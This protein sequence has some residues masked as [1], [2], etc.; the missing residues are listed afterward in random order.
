MR[1]PFLI[2][3]IALLLTACTQ[4]PTKPAAKDGS[5]I[6]NQ[7]E[8]IER[9]LSEAQNS[10]SPEREQ[11][12]LQ[13]AELLLKANQ[14]DLLE[15]VIGGIEPDQLPL[16]QH[17]SYAAILS[18][19]QIK[20]GLFQEALLTIDNQRLI[21]GLATLPIEQQLQISLLRAEVFALLGN[22]IASAQQR[23]YIAPL[24]D[25]ASL[26]TSNHQALWRSL[27]YVS[28]DDLKRY[29]ESTFRGE[30]QGWLELAII[31]KENQ[32]DLDEQVRQ[33]D[34]W[35][36]FWAEHPASSNLPGGLELIKELAANRPNKV[37]LLL[38][39]TDKLAPF[40]K[41]VR[42][43]F[44]AALYETQQ[45]GGKVPELAI[46][47][48]ENNSDVVALYHQAVAAGAEMVIGPLEK[49]R[50]RLLFDELA[51][52]VPTLALN[53]ID[54]Y[55]FAPMNMFQ[56]ALA[57]EDEAKQ[58]A[59]IAFLE[60]HKKAL[61]IAP[62]GEWGDRVRDTF[63]QRWEELGG[64]T[65]AESLY[66]GQSDYSSSIKNALQLDDSEERARR[67]QRLIGQT[68]EFSP[69]RREDIDMV[70]LLARPQQARSI[71]PLLAYHYAADLPVYGTSRLYAGY[72]DGN[73]DR[74][75][76]GV[77]FTDMPWVLSAS[78]TMHQ[79]INQE[80]VNSK[81][82]QRMYALGVDSY[83][84]HPRLRQLE[85]LTNSRVYGQT[86]TLKLN[87]KNEI[88]REMLYAQI[89]NSRAKIIPLVDQ[90]LSNATTTD[91]RANVL[92]SKK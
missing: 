31:A 35:Q 1:T 36:Q 28:K 56:F 10:L 40:G 67:I 17:V 81:P 16:E 78:S 24:L 50:V 73:K 72:T 88:E 43:G 9:L 47:D 22:H 39:L 23:I 80:L 19:L 7:A 29:W 57:P 84:L 70:F 12:Q 46:Y 3:F 54:D 91:G 37:A 49:H 62:Q 71:K 69:R 79:Q 92:E 18:Q 53:R 2:I 38:P 86:G 68:I 51:L 30:Y 6:S 75:I 48:T 21:E 44:V 66:S 27:M 45:R 14:L 59:E 87:D 64:T 5:Q 25:D 89:K 58:I 11:K 61:I 55:G 13:A 32:G 76:N 33:L 83:Q 85:E 15:Q 34:R 41:A 82:Y 20:S 8:L 26:Q 90:S 63:N 60:N 77:R 52:P 4:Q 65:I 42:D 74:D